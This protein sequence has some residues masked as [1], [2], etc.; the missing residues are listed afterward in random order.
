MKSLVS[1]LVTV[2]L[3]S[4]ACMRPE[5]HLAQTG[6]VYP[7][8]DGPVK[9]FKEPPEGV[10]YEE[11]GIVSAISRVGHQWAQLLTAMQKQAASVGG[12]GII[13]NE[14]ESPSFYIRIGRPPNRE[15]SGIAIRIIDSK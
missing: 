15:L 1:L 4:L 12:N 10:R 9:I 8:Y 14:P 5:V 3:L 7:P 6:T 2:S 13:L 11:I